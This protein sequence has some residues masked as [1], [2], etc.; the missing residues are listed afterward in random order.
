MV[1]RFEKLI[2]QEKDKLN[3]T[4]LWAINKMK[5]KP[6]MKLTNAD[7]N[8][9][10]AILT[11]KKIKCCDLSGYLFFDEKTGYKKF[12]QE[13]KKVWRCLDAEQWTLTLDYLSEM[14][15]EDA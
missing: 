3:I 4:D 7:R 15:G 12:N 14:V 8:Y 13:C 10:S 6:H 2:K 11:K 1:T 9:I 5:S